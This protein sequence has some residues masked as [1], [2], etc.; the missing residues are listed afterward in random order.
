MVIM[1]NYIVGFLALAGTYYEQTQSI[2]ACRA[3][4]CYRHNR[5]VDGY[6]DTGVRQGQGASEKG[7]LRQ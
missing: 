5:L 2:H 4:R 3:A 1:L 6:P 7:C